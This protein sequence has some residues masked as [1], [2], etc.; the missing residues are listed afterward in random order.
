M[1]FYTLPCRLSGDIRT[2]VAC[3]A[4]LENIPLELARVPLYVEV[5]KGNHPN[6]VYVHETI[7]ENNIYQ[8]YVNVHCLA[9]M[10]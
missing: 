2:A 1:S 9:G 4:A 5:R 7:L 6:L 8:T 3:D 10:A